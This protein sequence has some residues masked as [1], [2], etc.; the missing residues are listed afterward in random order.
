MRAQYCPGQWEET[1]PLLLLRRPLSSRV[2]QL[3]LDIRG[4]CLPVGD[5]DPDTILK[6]TSYAR[7]AHLKNL[8]NMST[9]GGFGGRGMGQ[10][11]GVADPSQW[12]RMF[13]VDID[14]RDTTELVRAAEA[15][16]SREISSLQPRLKRLFGRGAGEECCQ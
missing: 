1:S 10:T 2:P 11:C 9:I 16:S 12:M 7:A 4:H 5:D 13:G 15:A 3:I 6:I 14:S 8:L